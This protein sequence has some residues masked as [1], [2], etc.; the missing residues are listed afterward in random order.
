MF[1]ARRFREKLVLL[2]TVATAGAGLVA[3]GNG[4]PTK[5]LPVTPEVASVEQATTV[6]SVAVAAGTASVGAANSPSS[7]APGDETASPS[8]EAVTPSGALYVMG[9]DGVPEFPFEAYKGKPE[10]LLKD[11][12]EVGIQSWIVGGSNDPSFQTKDGSA[13]DLTD[14]QV[15]QLSDANTMKFAKSLFNEPDS[16]LSKI[17]IDEIATINHYNLAGNINSNIFIHGLGNPVNHI[18]QLSR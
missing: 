15:K 5:G 2:A 3:C 7:S 18:V 9:A 13:V 17:P 8:G 14:D 4:E 12:V 16:A 11:F 1:G 10:Q 6:S